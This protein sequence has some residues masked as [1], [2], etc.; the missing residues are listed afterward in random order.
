MNELFTDCNTE[1]Y[2][3]TELDTLNAAW[4]ALVARQGLHVGSEEY[5]T[6]AKR[7]SDLVAGA[8]MPKRYMHLHTGQV[9]TQDGWLY[10]DREG[11][12]RDPVGEG[13]AALVEV[14]KIDG[15]WLPV[16]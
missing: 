5:Y 10:E 15:E 3:Q 2:T 12:T 8:V 13:N 7:F 6:E 14:E 9:A 1:G 16:E 4:S 11:L